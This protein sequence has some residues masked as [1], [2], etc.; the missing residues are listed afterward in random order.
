MRTPLAER[1]DAR[2][3]PIGDGLEDDLYVVE[4]FRGLANR[5]IILAQ[6][7]GT[8]PQARCKACG[9]NLSL[10]AVEN[11]RPVNDE[12]VIATVQ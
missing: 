10:M 11:M 8:K 4:T 3:F 9:T 1:C 5:D 7:D 6:T 12:I 2:T